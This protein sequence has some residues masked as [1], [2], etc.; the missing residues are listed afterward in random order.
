MILHLKVL[1]RK[2]QPEVKMYFETTP[3]QKGGKTR[4]EVLQENKMW[5]FTHCYKKKSIVICLVG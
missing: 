5:Y 2:K 3:S 1:E 4:P